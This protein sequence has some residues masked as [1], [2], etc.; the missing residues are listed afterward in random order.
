MVEHCVLRETEADIT[1]CDHSKFTLLKNIES[2]SLFPSS[3][4]TAKTRPYYYNSVLVEKKMLQCRTPASPTAR[5]DDDEGTEHTRR[6]RERKEK[7]RY[8]QVP[9]KTPRWD[10]THTD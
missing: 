4:Q 1:N 6:K 7:V 5:F 8:E 9:T 3:Q 10:H 2:V